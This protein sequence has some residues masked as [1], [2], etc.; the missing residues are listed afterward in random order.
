MPFYEFMATVCKEACCAIAETHIKRQATRYDCLPILQGDGD[1][2]SEIVYGEEKILC[3][4]PTGASKEGQISLV[5]HNE[6][7]EPA[8]EGGRGRSYVLHESPF[9]GIVK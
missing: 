8:K 2:C 9:K 6:P 4:G 3:T 5:P 1:K 7:N